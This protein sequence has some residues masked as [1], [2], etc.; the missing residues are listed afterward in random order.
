MVELA[1]KWPIGESFTE[2]HLILVKHG[3]PL[4]ICHRQS[5][6]LISIMSASISPALGENPNKSTIDSIE[7]RWVIDFPYL[8]RYDA[9]KAA[10]VGR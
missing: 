5:V 4:A 6:T 3:L 8:F 9:A 7:K 1:N 10:Q 2:V